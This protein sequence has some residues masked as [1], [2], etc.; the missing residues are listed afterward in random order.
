MVSK[1]VQPTSSGNEVF[2]W[3]R[4]VFITLFNSREPA[5]G[6]SLKAILPYCNVFI[7]DQ[8][9]TDHFAIACP[10]VLAFWLLPRS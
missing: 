1:A 5:Q 2:N 4:H 8:Y 9:V 6:H 10:R 7:P 3:S